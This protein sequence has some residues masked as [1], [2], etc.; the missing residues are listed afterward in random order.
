MKINNLSFPH[1]VLGVGDDVNGNYTV[2]SQ[3]QLGRELIT[4]QI[5]HHLSNKTL[6]KLIS[7]NKAAF[8]MEVHCQQSVYRKSFLSREKQVTITVPARELLNKVDVSFYINAVSDIPDYQIDGSNEDYKGYSFDIR[9]G[10]ILAVYDSICFIAAKDW[11]A[12]MAVT[13]FMEIEPYDKEEGP[14]LFKLT[15]NKVVVQ[16]CQNDY[17]KFNKF[18]TAH[19]LNPIFHSS[20]VLPALM[21]ALSMMT[22]NKGEFSSAGWHQNLM[23]R[24][25]HEEN[26]TKYD[27][28]NSADIPQIAQAILMNPITRSLT[29]M[30]N[31][32][33]S[34]RL[35]E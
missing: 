14:M 32:Q 21:Y 35:E 26:L 22:A 34:Q 23:W 7:E 15:Q 8:N 28:E 16:M 12:F 2:E 6:E 11:Q 19:F 30:E 33:K 20:V 27:I 4:L 3:I 13:S 24:L 10:D 18:R 1:P 25:E 9:K 31:I 17:K 29:G 5:S